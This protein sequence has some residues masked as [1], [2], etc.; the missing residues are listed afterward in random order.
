MRLYS[1]RHR[2]E[3]MKRTLFSIFIIFTVLYSAFSS[4]K[5]EREIPPDAQMA[6]FIT[7]EYNN[8]KSNGWIS[9]AFPEKDCLLVERTEILEGLTYETINKLNIITREES[10]VFTPL[11]IDFID[12]NE[13]ERIAISKFL[14]INDN[15]IIITIINDYRDINKKSIY[16]DI[17]F[18]LDT[19][20]I[21]RLNE[22]EL[23]YDRFQNDANRHMITSP[24]TKDNNITVYFGDT[25]KSEKIK[26]PEIDFPI[27][28]AYPGYSDSEIILVVKKETS[29]D[30]IRWD[31]RK[32]CAIK[33]Y[34]IPDTTYNIPYFS[35]DRKYIA[36][37]SYNYGILL[38]DIRSGGT[39][40]IID[41][42][43]TSPV[44]FPLYTS[45]FWSWDSEVLY[46]FS[47]ASLYSIKMDEINW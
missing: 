39:V 19:G 8:T 37:F 28:I 5:A 2:L 46:I 35:P 41:T 40:H 25:R 29:I 33:T 42:E 31:F 15:D 6:T 18:S 27:D 11:S 16:I 30:L 20:K 9:R 38:I 24:K 23:N 7:N 34:N 36:L 22:N 12:L 13:L 10:I 45:A 32:E 47:D 44:Y 43:I 3:I 4:G 17:L 21:I 1:L 14:F 26:L